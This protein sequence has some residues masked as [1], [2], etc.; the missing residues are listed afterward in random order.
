MPDVRYLPFAIYRSLL[1]SVPPGSSPRR[2]PGS[3]VFVLAFRLQPSTIIMCPVASV[4]SSE[5]LDVA[6]FFRKKWPKKSSVSKALGRGIGYGV[7]VYPPPPPG[8]FASGCFAPAK[9]HP[10]ESRQLFAPIYR[11]VD[12]DME[13]IT[14]SKIKSMSSPRRRGS[15]TVACQTCIT[16]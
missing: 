2:K 15:T 4:V 11:K 5:P 13:N 12:T 8:P 6:P 10:V 3:S 16:A 14:T 7:A 1:Y 9:A